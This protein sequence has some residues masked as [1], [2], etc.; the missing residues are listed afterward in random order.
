MLHR[1]SYI[2]LYLLTYWES[3][4][5]IILYS[6]C[7]LCLSTDDVIVRPSLPSS[8]GSFPAASLD[9]FPSATDLPRQEGKHGMHHGQETKEEVH[10][11]VHM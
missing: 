1:S 2:A 4:W 5:K 11:Y 3:L 9:T 8:A 7:T 10:T 6:I